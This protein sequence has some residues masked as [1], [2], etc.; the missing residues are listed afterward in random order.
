MGNS[1]QLLE[2]G[3]MAGWMPKVE[4]FV[5]QKGFYV[6]KGHVKGR[7]PT[8]RAAEPG[9]ETRDLTAGTN[10]RPHQEHASIHP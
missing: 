10:V 7:S 8:G 3:A 6:F 1:S 5:C 9:C 4:V 2:E